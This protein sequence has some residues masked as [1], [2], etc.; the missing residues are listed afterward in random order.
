MPKSKGGHLTKENREVIA[1]GIKA[2]DLARKI[3]KR[4]DVSPSTVTREVKANRT[5]KTRKGPGRKG[6]SATCAK[7]YDCSRRGG[8]CESCVSPLTVCGDRLKRPCTELCP[9]FEL[10]MCSTTKK[11]LYV[12]PANCAKR[13]HCGFPKCSYDAEEAH[14]SHADRLRDSRSGIAIM[15]EQ[16]ADLDSVVTPLV[17]QGQSFE[18]IR[19]E[20]GDEMPVGVRTAYNYQG[21]SL[22]SCAN[23][24]LP[25]KAKCRPRKKATPCKRD[26]IDRTGCT[27]ADF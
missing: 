16:L 11:W 17:K 24:E 5:V 2:T 26:R 21:A 15:P 23:I 3:A 4:I 8:A 22:L 1:I 20:H 13:A 14:K 19:I 10:V 12:C 6:S 18:A 7:R 9:D 27:Y 25:R